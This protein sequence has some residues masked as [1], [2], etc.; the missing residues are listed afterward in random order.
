MTDERERDKGK[1]CR[2][3]LK[4]FP[5]VPRQINSFPEIEKK[6]NFWN[7]DLMQSACTMVVHVS[8]SEVSIFFSSLLLS[9]TRPDS[10]TKVMS[11]IR[12]SP[13]SAEQ[14][15][16]A[17]RKSEMS[18]HV[19]KRYVWSGTKLINALHYTAQ[20]IHQQ[21]YVRVRPVL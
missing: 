14:V 8:Y 12:V 17:C 20:S 1:E 9:R 15:S 6:N 16:R 21:M 10:H 3:S 2:K 5:Q 18:R 4:F 13:A 11:P 7:S 19:S